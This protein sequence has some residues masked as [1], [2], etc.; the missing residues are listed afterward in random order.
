MM[1]KNLKKAEVVGKVFLKGFKASVVSE[2]SIGTATFV[3]F[4]Q[5]LKYNGSLRRGINSGVVT[6]TILGTIDGVGTVAKN[7]TIIKQEC[8]KIEESEE[9]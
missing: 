8:K 6:L 1:N 3:G 9:E 2:S 4:Y 7:W 5:G